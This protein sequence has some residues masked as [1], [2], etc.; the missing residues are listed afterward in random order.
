VHLRAQEREL[1][2]KNRQLA[3]AHAASEMLKAE[4]VDAV[5][6]ALITIHDASE[7][8]EFS[9][10]AEQI[11]GYRRADVL[12]RSISETIIPPHLRERHRQGMQR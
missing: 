1:Q 6:D 7:I 3:Q 10:G 4:I 9:A 8:I 12:G 2:D 5:P 11:F